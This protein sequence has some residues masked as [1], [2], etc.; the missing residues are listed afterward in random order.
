M[1]GGWACVEA[2]LEQAAPLYHTHHLMPL[3]TDVLNISLYVMGI[4]K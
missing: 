2:F 1:Y 3:I 4:S